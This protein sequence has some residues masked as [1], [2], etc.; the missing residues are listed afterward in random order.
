MTTFIRYE[1]LFVVLY[2]CTINAHLFVHSLIVAVSVVVEPYCI[3]FFS[4]TL[5]MPINN[6]IF[7]SYE[8]IALARPTVTRI[9]LR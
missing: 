2:R 8:K 6:D 7:I 1:F 4:N 3:C 9:S 5:W